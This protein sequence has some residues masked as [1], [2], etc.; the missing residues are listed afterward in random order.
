MHPKVCVRA[1]DPRHTPAAYDIHIRRRHLC[2][3]LWTRVE[4]P[5]FKQSKTKRTVSLIPQCSAPPIG[6]V[7]LK[8]H[9]CR[10]R[11]NARGKDTKTL[12]NKQQLNKKNCKKDLNYLD[13]ST[14]ISTFAAK[15][16]CHG[17][18]RENGR[19]L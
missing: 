1:Q 2:I 10:I 4:F 19:A 7:L 5:R 16:I 6:S 18:K 17:L 12:W 3:C 13:I 9:R 8:G 11:Q 15:I 14:R